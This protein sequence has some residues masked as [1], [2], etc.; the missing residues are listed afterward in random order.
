MT[1]VNLWPSVAHALDYLSK[2]TAYRTVPKVKQ[3]CCN[4]CRSQCLEFWISAVVTVVYW[5]S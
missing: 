5:A 2:A 4:A 3:N 1:D